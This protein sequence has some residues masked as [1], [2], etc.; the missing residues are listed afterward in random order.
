[1]DANLFLSGFTHFLFG[2]V[3]FLVFLK[4]LNKPVDKKY[5]LLNA[6]NWGCIYIFF[7]LFRYLG[8]EFFYYGQR[9]WLSEF[10]TF[11]I[12]PTGLFIG[13][14]AGWLTGY[15][16]K[17]KAAP[18]STGNIIL[19]GAVWGLFLCFSLRF[20]DRNFLMNFIT[21]VIDG[22]SG[23]VVLFVILYNKI[24]LPKRNVPS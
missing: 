22:A 2:G 18:L 23:A 9:I 14:A 5:I 6:A 24:V 10:I 12:Y 11:H 20:G 17:R 13:F 3:V 4:W 19:S 7:T 16:L 1:M 8:I 21:S 15:L